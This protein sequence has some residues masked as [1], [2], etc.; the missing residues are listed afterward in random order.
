VGAEKSRRSYLPKVPISILGYTKEEQV[1]RTFKYKA[2]IN[3]V[4]EANCTRWLSLCQT[5]YNLCLEQRVLWYTQR[6][7]STSFY[8]QSKQ[9]LDLKSAFP[10]FAT[11]GSQVL[12]DVV[13]RVDLAFQA[14]FRRC[15]VVG[16]KAGFPRFKSLER[17]DSFTLRQHSWKLEGKYLTVRNVGRFKLFLSRPIEGRIKTVTI[18]RSVSGWFVHFSCDDVPAKVFPATDKVVGI[19]V[20]LTHYLVDSEGTRVENPRFF[21]EAEGV[22]RRRQR[23][24]SRR[25]KG[26][27]HRE[28]ARVLVAKAHE[29]VV[30]QRQDFLHKLANTYI[31][32]FGTVCVEDLGISN[33]VKNKYLAKSICDASWGTF[34]QMLTDKAEE[35]GRQLVKVN[36]RGTS[37]ICSGCDATVAKSLAVRTHRCP[38]CGLVLC[39]DHNA[40][41]NILRAGQAL[42]SLTPGLPGVG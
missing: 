11:V 28:K 42:Q 5:L 29:K 1:R 31:Q 26:S 41:L 15:R 23:R 40:A 19:D 21:R 7:A 25:K 18:K 35:A 8:S 3:R 24:L 14:F 33:M 4:T 38:D 16:A 2:K 34:I 9:L 27:R 12:A 22:L 39:R 36:P 10:E 37:Q 30:R 13:H 17:Y 6:R 20:G 32:E